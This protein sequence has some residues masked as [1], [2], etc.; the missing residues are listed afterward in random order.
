MILTEVVVAP[1][2]ERSEENGQWLEL[3]NIGN[4]PTDLSGCHLHM[5][6]MSTSL[7]GLIVGAGER[8]VLARNLDP[9]ANGGIQNAEMLDLALNPLG[10]LKVVSQ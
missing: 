3:S 9:A 6:A 4:T 5:A 10:T 1:A 2:D 7:D 8:A